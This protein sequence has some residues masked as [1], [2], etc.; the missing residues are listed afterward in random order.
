MTPERRCRLAAGFLALLA[1]V[2]LI[3]DIGLG[4]HCKSIYFCVIVYVCVIIIM[5]II[6][7][8]GFWDNSERSLISL[9]I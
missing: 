5:N 4:V 7:P 3:V 2:L 6:Y 8:K 9:F 1:A